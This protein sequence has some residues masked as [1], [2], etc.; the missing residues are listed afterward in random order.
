MKVE[1][2][3]DVTVQDYRVGTEHEE[4]YAAGD[5]PELSKGSALHWIKRGVAEPADAEAKKLAGADPAIVDMAKRRQ[6]AAEA[7]AAEAAPVR[8]AADP[9]EAAMRSRVR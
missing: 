1:F 3:Q 9:A 4:S 6:A 8:A 5:K 7:E 2:N